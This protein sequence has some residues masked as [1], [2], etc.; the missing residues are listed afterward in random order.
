MA[1]AVPPRPPRRRRRWPFVL[2]GLGALAVVVGLAHR[3]LIN[4]PL[5]RIV[6]HVLARALGGEAQVG[7]LDGSLVRDL[8]LRQVR[9]RAPLGPVVA[10]RIDRLHLRYSLWQV[11]RGHALDAARLVEAEGVEADLDFVRPS[12]PRTAARAGPTTLELPRRWPVLRI[13]GHLAVRVPGQGTGIPLTTDLEIRG[14][15]GAPIALSLRHLAAPALGLRD[16]AWTAAIDVR[17]PGRLVLVSQ[18]PLAGIRAQDVVLRTQ[19]ELRID[20]TLGI[21]SGRIDATWASAHLALRCSGVDTRAA[22]AVLRAVLPAGVHARIDGTATL[23]FAP[24]SVTAALRLHDVEAFGLHADAIAGAGSVSTTAAT[25]TSLAVS[26]APVTLTVIGGS[27]DLAH[28]QLR[29]LPRTLALRAPD[30]RPLLAWALAHRLLDVRLPPLREAVALQLEATGVERT[31]QVATLRLAGGG[32]L[33]AHGTLTLPETATWRAVRLEL[34][35][36][37]DLQAG[38]LLDG[39]RGRLH[40]TL[41]GGG[42]LADPHGQVQLQADAVA[43]R[44]QPLGTLTLAAAGDA[45]AVR[46]TR[47]ALTG[48]GHADLHGTLEPRQRRC[49]AVEL[50][51]DHLDLAAVAAALGIAGVGGHAQ[52]MIAL[53]HATLPA[54]RPWSGLDQLG[55]RAGLTLT[56]LRWHDQTLGTLHLEVGGDAGRWRL[57][58]C[59]L[60]PGRAGPLRAELA[61]EAT[62]AADHVAVTLTRLALI[63]TAAPAL[64]VLLQA[65]VRAEWRHGGSWGRWVVDQVHLACLGGRVDGALTLTDRIVDGHLDLLHLRPWDL[66]QARLGTT[67]GWVDCS[68]R[69]TGVPDDPHL[70][71]ALDTVGARL[72]TRGGFAL[73]R[74]EIDRHGLL[75]PEVRVHLDR[76]LEI[77]GAGVVPLA[78]GPHRQGV[79][80]TAADAQLFIR[81]AAVPDLLPDATT[82]PVTGLLDAAITIDAQ[83]L[84][85]RAAVRELLLRLPPEVDPRQ[86]S[87]RVP[88]RMDAQLQANPHGW[89]AQVAVAAGEDLRLHATAAGELA[90]STLAPVAFVR[91]FPRSP[92]R[93]SF[94]IDHLELSRVQGFVPQ[95][96]RMTG[97]VTGLL[98]ATGTPADPHWDGRLTLAGVAGRIRAALPPFTDGKGVLVVHDHLLT[99]E[100]LQARLGY[101]PVAVQGTIDAAPA[102][103]VVDLAISGS[104][105]LLIESEY[106][107]LRLDAAL[108]VTGPLQALRCAGSVTVTDALYS[109]PF[110]LLSHLRPTSAHEPAPME[111]DAG[112][113]LFSIRSGP[114]ANVAFDVHLHAV[115]SIHVATDLAA[116]AC[117]CELHLGGT[118]LAPILTGRVWVDDAKLDLP[119]S[120]LTLTHAQLTFGADDPYAPRLQANGETRLR[121]YDLTVR[122]EGRLP[123]VVVTVDSDPPLPPNDGILLLTTGLTTQDREEA[124]ANRTQLTMVGEYLAKQIWGQVGPARNPDA[125]DSLFDLDRLTLSVGE[126]VTINGENTIDAEYRLTS[127]LYLH[128]ERDIFDQYNLLLV[129]RMRSR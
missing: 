113:P 76:C 28:R 20:A 90:L 81:A 3:P 93:L 70:S 85:V 82:W 99:I 2:L 54:D 66:A 91:A 63:P 115:Q 94:G 42:T 55:G 4:R 103:P 36:A 74:A 1:D 44:D 17:D 35:A 79:Q 124:S 84:R 51:L 6:A 125:K 80:P 126:Q 43:V 68:L 33:V 14:G 25:L 129:W 109:Q 120:T 22:P 119:F 100:T 39:I 46:L 105:A 62:G 53:A 40:G 10:V 128:G 18:T 101:A 69:C 107:R 47:L 117:S 75:V 23:A 83:G 58:S 59:T 102:S 37:V 123:D 114:L 48:P 122:I 5:A 77:Q 45:D 116:G 96:V 7:A 60:D 87:L 9:V 88:T 108:H 67:A 16:A 38:V 78:P 72:G 61:G 111:T 27:V 26:G 64:A 34:Q 110:D 52:G 21:G 106:L 56:D 89:Q 118:G 12:A 49:Q 112:I 97:Q 11:L 8:E 13:D 127:W 32:A 92:A 71:L 73:I 50:R 98:R 30:L 121:G 95:L 24:W 29:A 31:L 86:A 57:G 15:G 41:S 19:P 65:P 104:N